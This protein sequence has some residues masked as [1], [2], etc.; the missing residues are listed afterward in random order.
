MERLMQPDQ[1]R[2][3]ILLWAEEEMRFNHLLPKSGSILKA[4]RYRG[5]LA[6]ADAANIV[7]TGERQARRVVSALLEHG[8]L[9]SQSARAPAPCLPRDTRRALDAWFVPRKDRGIISDDATTPGASWLGALMKNRSVL[10]INCFSRACRASG[11]PTHQFPKLT[12]FAQS[13]P[14]RSRYGIVFQGLRS[15]IIIPCSTVVFCIRR[16]LNSM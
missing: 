14:G 6:C 10:G 9:T 2:T 3:R 5:E 16:T 13:P 8:V 15:L 11:H 4:V 7:G 1:L 12:Q